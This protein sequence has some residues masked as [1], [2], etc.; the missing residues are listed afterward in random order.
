MLVTKIKA[1]S[2]WPIMI[3][4]LNHANTLNSISKHKCSVKKYSFVLFTI[5]SKYC[6]LGGSRV[7]L[8][9]GY[10]DCMGFEKKYQF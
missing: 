7:N 1:F 4:Y 6:N 2:A 5:W 3:K 8:S 10:A 9:F